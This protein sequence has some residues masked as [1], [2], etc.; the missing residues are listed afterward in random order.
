MKDDFFIVSVDIKEE[1][2]NVL[3][4][5]SRFFI[6]T[7]PQDETRKA[8]EMILT[9]EGGK[10]LKQGITV[11]GTGRH[12]AL[13]EKMKKTFDQGLDDLE[14]R[15][16]EFSDQLKDLPES[17]EYEDLKEE[18]ERFYREMKNAGEKALKKWENE[19]VPRLKKQLEEL[20][21]RLLTPPKKEAPEE[22]IA[23]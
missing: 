17:K 10:P 23:I 22:P 8:V 11:D 18:L 2:E 5:H 12:A 14:S 19:L 13:L 7:D 3:T 4:E 21:E 16:K 1:F 6:N 20:E 15:F 9:A